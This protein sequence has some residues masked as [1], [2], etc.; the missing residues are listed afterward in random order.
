M[1]AQ[2]MGDSQALAN[3]NGKSMMRGEVSNNVLPLTFGYLTNSKSGSVH[4]K[5]AQTL[6]TYADLLSSQSRNKLLFCGNST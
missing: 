6:I 1:L 3:F 5:P 2:G 4:L